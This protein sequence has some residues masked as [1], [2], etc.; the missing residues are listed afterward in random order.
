MTDIPILGRRK[1]AWGSGTLLDS[2]GSVLKRLRWTTGQPARV[3]RLD[4]D[5]KPT[6]ITAMID[7]VTVVFDDGP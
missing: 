7:R 4:A 6:E 1:P 5:G 3:I 2:K